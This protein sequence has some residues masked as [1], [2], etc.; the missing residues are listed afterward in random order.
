[1]ARGPL[2][3]ETE[4]LVVRSFAERDISEIVDYSA[5]GPTDASR[6][7]NIDWE[8][9]PEG[10]RAWW[11]PM[12]AMGIDEAVRW[13]ALVIEV[14]ALGRVVGNV[15]LR[16]ESVVGHRQALIGWLLG[17]AFEGRGYATEATCVLLDHLFLSEGFHRAYARTGADNERSRRLMERVGMRREGHFVRSGFHD[18]SW[19]DEYLYAV[20]D[21]EWLARR[22]DTGASVA[23]AP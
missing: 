4:R 15:G 19:C 20:L 8:P 2:Y 3:L 17:K 11:T 16:T 14:K 7:R 18:G 1:M 13:L 6:L 5:C 22:C 10:V 23:R 12:A 9:T 21:S